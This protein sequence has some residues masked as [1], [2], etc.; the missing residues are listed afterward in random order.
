MRD[1]AMRHSECKMYNRNYSEILNGWN[2][3][4]INH[5]SG[6]FKNDE[7]INC[8]D[9]WVYDKSVYPATVISEV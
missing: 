8:K 4:L 6:G 7:I 1:G 2:E 3:T 9:G 5:V